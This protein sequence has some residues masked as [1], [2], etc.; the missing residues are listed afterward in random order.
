MA[1]TVSNV[2]AG[3]PN[4]GGAIYV[5]AAGATLPTDA[6]TALGTG[7]TCLGYASE[8]GLTNENTAETNEV[9]AWGGDVVAT[10]QT[11]K[12]DRFKFKL[13]EI[14]SVD[15]LKAVYG[16]D[17]VSGTLSA[18]ITVKANSAA[19]KAVSWVFD[20]V[21]G[22]AVKRIVVPQ[23]RVSEVAEIVY[24]DDDVVG[25]DITINAEPY[26]TYSGDTH[27]EFIKTAGT[28]N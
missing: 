13:I 6:V 20:L 23:G 18:G 19:L 15:V 24:K 12:P 3:K 17:N 26:S 22:S 2:A 11:S 1:N 21:L 8:D 25:Y 7:W 5:A 16:A 14:L 27:R 10:L 4:I 9:K 28:G